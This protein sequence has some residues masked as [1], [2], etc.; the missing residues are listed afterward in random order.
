[1]TFDLQD[2]AFD[3]EESILPDNWQQVRSIYT[4]DI[5]IKKF[6]CNQAV[7]Q[8]LK[9]TIKNN[10]VEF[11]LLEDEL[12]IEITLVY[13]LTTQELLSFNCQGC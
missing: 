13:S 2:I 8:V 3:L 12:C 5:D 1:M 9:V 6:D 11:L 10:K 4:E 7:W